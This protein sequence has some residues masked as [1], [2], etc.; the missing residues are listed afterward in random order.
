MCTFCTPL[1]VPLLRASDDCTPQPTCARAPVPVRDRACNLLV[2]DPEEGKEAAMMARDI[3]HDLDDI[4]DYDGLLGVDS[5]NHPYP[6]FNTDGLYYERQNGPHPNRYV[7]V[8]SPGGSS[9]ALVQSGTIL[10]SM[11]ALAPHASRLHA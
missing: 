3:Y 5:G 1:A 2:Q 9:G 4:S 10:T 6:Y 11:R 7:R 8:K